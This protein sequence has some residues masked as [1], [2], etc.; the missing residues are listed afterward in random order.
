MINFNKK[1]VLMSM[2]A[3]ALFFSSC[4]D[5]FTEQDLL[6]AQQ[7]VDYT[8]QL[9]DLNAN[10]TDAESSLKGVKVSLT[11]GAAV[12]TVE[13]DANGYVSFGK[14]QVGN[15]VIKIV[16]ENYLNGEA[17]V[18]LVTSN[19]KISQMITRFPVFAMTEGNTI[20][21]SGKVEVESDLTNSTRELAPA[22]T[23]I[24]VKLNSM[25]DDFT[26]VYGSNAGGGISDY[27]FETIVTTVKEDGTYEVVLPATT[28]GI[29]YSINLQPLTLNQKLAVNGLVGEEEISPRVVDIS[30]EFRL[31]S[32]TGAPLVPNVL[33]KVDGKYIGYAVVSNSGRISHVN[34]ADTK[35]KFAP[36]AELNATVEELKGKKGTGASVKV[37]T[38][39]NGFVQYTSL[40]AEG[41]DYTSGSV[42]SFL[43]FNNP[44]NSF[45]V[46]KGNTSQTRNFHY[47][48]GAYR[49]TEI[50]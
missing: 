7:Q 15:A 47:G 46:V 8:L 50:K 21:V 27:K 24:E 18:N 14:V 43:P 10:V 48:A 17:V 49:S 1:S 4:E 23:K 12:K 20:K 44:S 38:N 39:A 40:E 25:N 16:S 30:T 6:N 28:G 22:G 19:S 9:V 41:S 42:N 36:N 31:N 37:Y 33:L 45:N 2:M 29:N 11:Q 13:A 3:G 35:H 5:K 34:L 32:E 26:W